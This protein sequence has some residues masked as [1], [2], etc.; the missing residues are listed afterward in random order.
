[1]A[2]KKTVIIE[3]RFDGPWREFARTQVPAM[4]SH[5]KEEAARSNPG[6]IVRERDK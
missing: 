6:A 4:I 3:Y 5:Y 1:M 2:K